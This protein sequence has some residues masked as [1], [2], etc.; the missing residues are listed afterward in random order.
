MVLTLI[1]KIIAEL[2]SSSS[3]KYVEESKLSLLAKKQ[4]VI[5]ALE[6][7]V[8]DRKV[9]CCNI[10]KNGR[11][12]NV[13]WLSFHV[14]QPKRDKSLESPS[15]SPKIKPRAQV[16]SHNPVLTTEKELPDRWCKSCEIKH[17]A[18]EFAHSRS[19]RC[20]PSNIIYE[21]NK[22]EIQLE[23]VRQWRKKNKDKTG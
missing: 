8:Q 11:S 1:D 5:N 14:T 22:K 13:Y 16:K 4:D 12:Y 20:I 3:L 10:T 9:F 21:Q 17:L 18:T 2:E 7:L 19:R 23:R 15:L 6:H